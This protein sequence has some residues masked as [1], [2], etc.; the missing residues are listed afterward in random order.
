MQTLSRI[1][2]TNTP[3][4]TNMAIL[5]YQTMFEESLQEEDLEAVKKDERVAE[6][7]KREEE[8]WTQNLEIA[9]QQAFEEGRKQAWL[10][11]EQKFENEIK[12]NTAFYQRIIRRM[13]LFWL[14][15][16]EELMQALMTTGFEVAKEII[17]HVQLSEEFIEQQHQKI[18]ELL[19]KVEAHSKPVLQVSQED[20][21]RILELVK[22]SNLPIQVS[23]E[24]GQG[25]NKGEFILDTEHEGWIGV[26]RLITEHFQT[27]VHR[28]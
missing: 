24:A 23:I 22:G 17:D 7:L 21:S 5:N 26:Q 14:E 10:E 28:L 20:E 12:E 8:K 25:F 18:L 15:Q 27:H 2:T 19:H 6:L 3:K 1:S 13:G 16:K 11:A 4:A 9:K